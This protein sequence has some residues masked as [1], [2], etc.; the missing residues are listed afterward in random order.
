MSSRLSKRLVEFRCSETIKQCWLIQSLCIRSSRRNRSFLYSYHLDDI[1][2]SEQQTDVT[3]GARAYAPFPARRLPTTSPPSSHT[4]RRTFVPP[5]RRPAPL[6]PPSSLDPDW[7]R[8]PSRRCCV[9]FQLLFS[10]DFHVA[11]TTARRVRRGVTS[12]GEPA[13]RTPPAWRTREQGFRY[14]ASRGG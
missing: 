9:S 7:P 3:D 12:G 13:D 1:C 2:L 8:G 5:L 6:W 11:A 14:T 4:S 10:P